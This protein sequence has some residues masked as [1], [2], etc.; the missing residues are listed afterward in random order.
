MNIEATH[1]WVGVGGQHKLDTIHG[2]SQA[3]FDVHNYGH[4]FGTGYGGVER[5]ARGLR[6]RRRSFVVNNFNTRYS[7]GTIGIPSLARPF[8]ME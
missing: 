8:A 6:L 7:P 3:I 5:G 1:I 2:I 4:E